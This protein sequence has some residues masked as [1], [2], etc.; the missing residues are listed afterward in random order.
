MSVRKIAQASFKVGLENQKKSKLRFHSSPDDAAIIPLSTGYVYVSNAEVEGGKW[1]WHDIVI[2][3]R[4]YHLSNNT[5][6][7]F[8]F[9]VCGGVE[10]GGGVYGVYFDHDDNVVGYRMLL[11]GTT[12]NC[13][14]GLS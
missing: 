4:D 9:R 10:G 13:S 5:S 6:S 14:G 3:F 11:S 7:L 1:R 2:T 8:L 12:R